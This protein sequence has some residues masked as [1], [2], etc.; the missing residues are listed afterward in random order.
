MY[1]YIYVRTCTYT[2]LSTQFLS[3]SQVLFHSRVTS[4]LSSSCHPFHPPINLG[5]MR[6]DHGNTPSSSGLPYIRENKRGVAITTLV[7][8]GI[9]TVA[10]AATAGIVEV[11]EIEVV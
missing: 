11:E 3:I 7:F 5:S 4:L 10:A 9:V 8:I 1:I 2:L 6:E